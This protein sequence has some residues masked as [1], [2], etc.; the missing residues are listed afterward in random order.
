MRKAYYSSHVPVETTAPDQVDYTPRRFSAAE[1]FR[2]GEAGILQEEDRVELIEGEILVRE[3][4]GSEHASHVDEIAAL[5]YHLRNARRAIVRTNHPAILDD[6][7]VPQPDIAL[8]KWRDDRYRQAH[9]TPGH[10]LLAIEVS[11][12]SA[13]HDRR[14]KA[15]LYARAGIPELWIVDLK[16]QQLEVYRLPSESG[17]ASFSR[18][19]RGSTLRPIAF[20]DVE[21]RVEEI[22]LL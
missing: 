14:I 20:Q 1:Y 9:P 16:S 12:S 13:L 8:V 6:F 7:N 11:W 21:V 18:L 19:G 17:Y 3:P 2:M 5:F 22:L 4:E 15:P 10:I